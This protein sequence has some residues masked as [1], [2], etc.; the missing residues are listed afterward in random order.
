ML[1][2]AI[3]MARRARD[4]AELP[5]AL[6]AARY[7]DR[8]EGLGTD[9]GIEWAIEEG[10]SWLSRAQDS[11]PMRDGGV[12]RHYGLR[13]GWGASYPETTGYIAPTLLEQ[14]RLRNDESLRQHAKRMLDWLVSIQLPG[15]GFQ[16][17]MVNQ[18]PVVP[19]TFN[20]G[21]IL[22]GLAAGV[23]EFGDVFRG[24]LRAAA[25]WLVQTQDSDGCWRRHPTPFA[26]PGE[27]AYE[28]HVAWGLIE[29][30]RV[31][32]GR[33]YV[34]AAVRNVRWALTHQRPNGWFD[35][36]CLGDPIQPLSH[37]IGYVLRGLLEVH[38]FTA[39]PS[40]LEAARRTADGVLNAIRRDGTL[41]GKLNSEWR[42]TVD[43]S[44][45]TGNVQIAHSLLILY[46]STGHV[47]YRDGAYALNRSV[48]RTLRRDDPVETRG[49]VK[50]SFPIDGDYNPFEYPNWATKFAIDS[51]TLER[52]VREKEL[53]ATPRLLVQSA[54]YSHSSPDAD[55]CW[56]HV[57][58]KVESSTW[59]ALLRSCHG[60]IYHSAEWATY[61]RCERP[62]AVP[63]FYTLVDRDGS[64]A[65]VALGFHARSSRTLAAQF[66]GRRWLDAL[67]AVRDKSADTVSQFLRLIENHAR[68]A[69]DVT[70]EVG[71]FAS[72]QSAGILRPLGFSLRQRLEFELDLRQPEKALWAG[73]NQNRQRAVK[74]AMKTGVEVRE[75]PGEEG[76][77]HLRRLQEESFVRIASR[78]G[79]SLTKTQFGNGDPLTILT[80]AGV[81]RIVGGFVE[82]V[83]VSATLF[84]VFNGLAY[85]AM[86]GH[87]SIG[88]ESRAPSLVVWDMILR[89]RSEGTLK[90]N[91]GGCGAEAL[92]ESSPE[93]GVFTYKE[94]FGGVRVECA[95]G[96]K[97]LRP[98]IGRVTSLLRTGK[99]LTA[100]PLRWSR[101]HG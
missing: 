82:G 60:T 10:L 91:L 78:G 1:Q 37:T 33:G 45:L 63:E 76:A 13:D 62:N 17:G 61:T 101:Q 92:D 4:Y 94:A 42:G 73:M 27:K 24:P 85:Y 86:A 47:A 68:G 55:A 98:A 18:T 16:G 49:A 29:A 34:E 74:R 11:S 67:P 75:L 58:S 48:R 36:C 65:G 99:A 41:P 100:S 53:G 52:Q 97:T 12:A 7:R 72:P 38:R 51:Y 70:L 40:M 5:A 22:I 95:N 14:S 56:L 87:D 46:E 93:H 88:L 8:R 81:A 83:C 54:P 3:E 23:S 21:Q 84:T 15:G 59:N 90:L 6:K 77:S 43:W 57:A 30:E 20:T 69:G 89:L 32:G 26:G 71:S 19:V 79:P 66:S 31:D 2:S 28:T 50:G 80:G 25:D 64:I 35:R 39:D 96:A 9:P 44:C